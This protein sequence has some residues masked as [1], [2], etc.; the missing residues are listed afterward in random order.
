MAEK[1]SVRVHSLKRF[2]FMEQIQFVSNDLIIVKP[3]EKIL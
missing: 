3:T 2:C 1:M